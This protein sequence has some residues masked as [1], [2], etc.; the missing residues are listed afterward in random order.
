MRNLHMGS[1]YTKWL[2][3]HQDAQLENGGVSSTIPYAKHFP[4]VDP[5][6]PTSYA[7]LTHLLWQYYNDTDI[8]ARH[9]PSIRAFLQFEQ[10][11]TNCPNCR[12]GHNCSY[13]GLISK[14]TRKKK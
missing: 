10:D 9:Y 8:V 14:F 12:N 7:Q 6:W 13:D 1:F 5:S 4:P 3:D 11:V 2:Q